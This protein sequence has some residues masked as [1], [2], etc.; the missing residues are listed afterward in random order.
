MA[1]TANSSE[2]GFTFTFFPHTKDPHGRRYTVPWENFLGR[3][4]SPREYTTKQD[5]PLWSPASFKQD[6][7]AAEN[8]ERV[9]C[10]VYDIDHHTTPD[11]ITSTLSDRRGVAHTTFSTT[12]EDIRW[13]VIL[14]TSRSL[15][16]PEHPRVWRAGAA[17]LESG[18]IEYDRCTKDASRAWYVPARRPVY[19]CLQFHGSIIDVDDALAAYP[20]PDPE[21]ITLPGV[22]DD[23]VH[24]R[25]A[26]YVS[27]MQPAVSGQGGHRQTFLAA[28]A[29]TRGFNLSPDVALD[30][31]LTHF[32]PRCAPPWS[33]SD[34]ERKVR[35]A[36]KR[37]TLPV[38]WL[39]T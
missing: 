9:S 31:L 11:V 30:I 37:G 10:L 7:R 34:L 12:A 22:P 3:I 36:H 25:A 6:H 2:S 20:E 26:A 1:H 28:L 21:P 13:R 5:A 32:N 8:V 17:I 39:A 15:S 27:A 19:T 35:D 16:A 4:V 14:R 18:G 29:L 33:R 23:R 24:K 38:G